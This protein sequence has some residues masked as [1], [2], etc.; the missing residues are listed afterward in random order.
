V[1]GPVGRRRSWWFTFRCPSCAAY[2]FG[3]AATLDAVTKERRVSCGHRVKVV[4][5][6]IYSQP[7]GVAA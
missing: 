6:R 3:R 2:L 1:F 4:A 5:A 7:P